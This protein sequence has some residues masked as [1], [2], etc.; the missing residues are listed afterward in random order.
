MGDAAAKG[1]MCSGERNHR[2]KLTS[3]QVH[4]I[5]AARGKA[6]LRELSAQYGVSDAQ[7]SRIQLYQRRR[8]G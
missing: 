8:A 4:E 5:R 3:E 1:R 6:T 2:T 7:V